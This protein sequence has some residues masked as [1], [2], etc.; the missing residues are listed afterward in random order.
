MNNHIYSLNINSF[1]VVPTFFMT[2]FVFF[3]L[4]LYSILFDRNRIVLYSMMIELTMMLYQVLYFFTV[5]SRQIQVVLFFAKGLYITFGM[6]SI[7]SVFAISY[8]SN[9]PY[10]KTKI[11]VITSTLT[12]ILLTAFTDSILLTGYIIEGAYNVPEKG[13]LFILFVINDGVLASILIRRFLLLR[14]RR[15]QRF[16]EVWPI[17]IGI[18]FFITQTDLMVF[19]LIIK[20]GKPPNMWIN[21]IVF[22]IMIIIYLFKEVSKNLQHRENMYLNYIYDELSGVHSRSYILEL[23]EST[24]QLRINKNIYVTMIDIDGFKDVNDTF[25]HLEGD[26]LLQSFGYLLT[27]LN[28]DHINAGRLGGDEFILYSESLVEE[29][30]IETLLELLADYEK[31]VKGISRRFKGESV[32][33]G[34][35][36]GI[37]KPSTADTSKE[38]L[39][40]I[41]HAMYSAKKDGKNNFHIYN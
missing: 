29:E 41:D 31:L 5:N 23:L 37:Y 38:I 40:K 35:N 24:K 9:E 1:G 2:L 39:T 27:N 26:H 30:L 11:F 13:P 25:G 14:K 33:T 7:I 28:P 32:E 18:I 20:P 3:S 15:R 6:L 22:T 19:F 10:I 36:I 12:L 21:S 4:L 8:I 34:L 17:H 16:D